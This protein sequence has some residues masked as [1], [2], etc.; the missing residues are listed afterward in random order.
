VNG[1]CPRG[2]GPESLVVGTNLGEVVAVTVLLIVGA[3]IGA[4]LVVGVAL[5]LLIGRTV[6]VADRQH[7]R[8]MAF[9]A[10]EGPAR[11]T[12]PAPLVLAAAQ[13]V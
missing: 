3:V 12:A 5:A 7:D 2:P 8:A 9:R 10:V 11:V 1:G 6:Q 4:W 13:R